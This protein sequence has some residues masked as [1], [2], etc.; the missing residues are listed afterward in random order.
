[1]RGKDMTNREKAAFFAD[2][3][4]VLIFSALAIRFVFAPAIS[5]L[6]PFLI[7]YVIA[8]VLRVPVRF[9]SEKTKISSGVIST[10][11]VVGTVSLLSYGI[12]SGVNKLLG[13]VGELIASLG[14]ENSGIGSS[15]D[16]I[17][18]AVESISSHIPVLRDSGEGVR[19]ISE[20]IDAF[21]KNTVN[22]SLGRLSS[23]MS[24]FVTGT[25]KRLPETFLYIIITVIAS[26]YISS[27][28]EHLSEIIRSLVPKRYRGI[29]SDIA[30]NAKETARRYFRAY[31]LIYL[32]TFG[33]L[34][35]GFSLMRVR[36][37]FFVALLVAFVD[38]LPVFGVG[39]VLI[40]WA[41]ASFLV[42]NSR[43][44]TSLLLL[45]AVITVVRQVAEPKIVG[46]SLGMS[47]LLTLFSMFAGY[48]L[49]GVLGMIVFPAVAYIAYGVAVGRRKEEKSEKKKAEGY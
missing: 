30:S 27:D 37:G 5:V 33:E 41:L 14:S 6:L 18:S 20:T 2:A 15:V 34:F 40:P 31:S 26:V 46:E 38:I 11:L 43:M 25:L 23:A 3:A 28:F 44:F 8:L 29:A 32:I 47:P 21:V 39:T 9:L 19:K 36:Y 45:Y 12:W 35:F 48:R 24:T 7:A 16:R 13:E 42:G 22:E 1:M 49:L 4:I 17:M 10:L